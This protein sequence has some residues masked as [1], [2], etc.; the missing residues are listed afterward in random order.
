MKLLDA[1]H[2][3][4]MYPNEVSG[5]MLQRAMIAIAIAPAPDL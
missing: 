3:M 4:K 2:V 1:E 5:G